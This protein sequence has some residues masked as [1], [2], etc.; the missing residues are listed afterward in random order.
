MVQNAWGR[1]RIASPKPRRD[2][3]APPGGVRKPDVYRPVLGTC[4][5]PPGLQAALPPSS[6]EE[7]AA[8]GP[9]AWGWG[10]NGWMAGCPPFSPLR[11]LTAQPRLLRGG[12]VTHRCQGVLSAFLSAR[13]GGR[14]AAPEAPSCCHS[15]SRVCVFVQRSIHLERKESSLISTSA[16]E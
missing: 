2:R 16:N 9:W 14:Q 6:L 11:G 12:A 3:D 4:R 10:T 8:A 5:D 13:P 15:T 1:R 7:E